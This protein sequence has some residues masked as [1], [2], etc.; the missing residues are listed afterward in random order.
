MKNEPTYIPKDIMG[1]KLDLLAKHI[2]NNKE[3]YTPMEYKWSQFVLWQKAVIEKQREA[4]EKMVKDF[5]PYHAGEED[6]EFLR[7]E[8]NKALEPI[9]FPLTIV[10]DRC[11]SCE[12]RN[13]KS[14][15][16]FCCCCAGVCDDSNCQQKFNADAL[17]SELSK[18]TDD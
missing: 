11:M 16:L 15:I 17:L 5:S 8:A 7:I 3:S 1:G 14:P 9:P 4:L 2:I 6:R 13:L 12:K 10:T 18:T